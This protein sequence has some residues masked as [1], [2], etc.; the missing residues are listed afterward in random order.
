MSFVRGFAQQSV[1]SPGPLFF[2]PQKTR[3]QW[4]IIFFI[5]AAIYVCGTIFFCVFVQ[6]SLQPWAVP[7]PEVIEVD[8]LH[9]AADHKHDREGPLTVEQSETDTLCERAINLENENNENQAV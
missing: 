9:S 3:E 7:A 8:P 6:T 1:S 5:T 2:F 4:Q